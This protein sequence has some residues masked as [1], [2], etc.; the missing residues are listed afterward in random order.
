MRTAKA[1]LWRHQQWAGWGE[2][3]AA[4]SAQSEAT[5][6]M[7]SSFPRTARLQPTRD[8]GRDASAFKQQMCQPAHGHPGVP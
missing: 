2:R 6:Q 3:R 1:P 5:D 4:V 8:Q 7:L